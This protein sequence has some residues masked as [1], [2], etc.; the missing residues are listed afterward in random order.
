MKNSKTILGFL[1]SKFSSQQENIVTDALTFILNSEEILKHKF[2]EWIS[3]KLGF[4]IDTNLNIKTQSHNAE[5][6]AI[7]DVEFIT[8]S[9]ESVIILE[10]KFWAGLTKYQPNTYF[11]RLTNASEGVLVF[12]VPGQRKHTI[13]PE[14]VQR[15]KNIIPVDD[16]DSEKLMLKHRSKGLLIRLVHP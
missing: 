7:P 12:I 9:L 5:D 4:A 3:D 2:I 1:G 16:I 8:D 11:E 14:L 15:L 10:N 6:D 13:W